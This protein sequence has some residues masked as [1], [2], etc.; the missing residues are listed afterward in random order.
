MQSNPL[1]EGPFAQALPC[2]RGAERAAALLRVEGLSV[3]FRAA[4]RGG[5]VRAVDD[6]SFR[7]GRGGSFGI[8]GES[9]CG[10]STLV[11]ALLRLVPAAGGRVELDGVDL[12]SAPAGRLRTLRRRAQIVFQ[13]PQ[14]SLNPRL[15][16]DLIVGEALHAH[17]LVRSAAERRERVALL[18]KDV[19]LAADALDCYPHEFSGGQR[20]RIAIARILSM[21]PEVLICDESVSA[22][23]VS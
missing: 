6:V 16:V 12:L 7:V 18:L 23:D 9:G 21:K 14:A 22:L 1:I 2:G 15:T 10:K 19:G 5:V 3:R 8:V 11:R 13:D 17:R 20:Q 4:G